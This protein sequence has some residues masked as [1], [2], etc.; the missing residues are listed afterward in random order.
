MT[1]DNMTDPRILYG[2]YQRPADNYEQ[3]TSDDDLR[4]DKETDRRREMEN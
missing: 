1:M 4:A 3:D 2:P